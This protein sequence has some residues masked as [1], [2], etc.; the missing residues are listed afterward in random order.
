MLYPHG[1]SASM[2]LQETKPQKRR[3]L[4]GK[5]DQAFT[6]PFPNQGTVNEEQNI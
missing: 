6:S 4:R 3:L 1:R 5:V 2:T